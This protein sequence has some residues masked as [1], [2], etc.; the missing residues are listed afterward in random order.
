MTSLKLLPNRNRKRLSVARHASS[1][2]EFDPSSSL[3]TMMLPN[4]SLFGPGPS[5]RTQASTVKCCSERL[6]ESGMSTKPP[7]ARVKPW[8]T[9][10]DT[11][12]TPDDADGLFTPRRSLMDPSIGHQLT[13][14]DGGDTQLGTG[15]LVDVCAGVCVG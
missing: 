7:G 11:K 1:T 9:S 12:L 15:V 10:P 3:S 2:E 14:P 6:G 5:G 8:P 4:S 13:R